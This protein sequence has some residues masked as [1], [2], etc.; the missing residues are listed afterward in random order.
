MTKFAISST[1]YSRLLFFSGQGCNYVFYNAERAVIP[2]FKSNNNA[3][4][5]EGTQIT[6]QNTTSGPQLSLDNINVE[7]IAGEVYSIEGDSGMVLIDSNRKNGFFEVQA[8]TSFINAPAGHMKK[9]L[10]SLFYNIS[11]LSLCLAISLSPAL[12]YRPRAY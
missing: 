4:T 7:C 8:G 9:L 5:L 3:L 10:V 12:F 1:T 11:F 2:L 6:K